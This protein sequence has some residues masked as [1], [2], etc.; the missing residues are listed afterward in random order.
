M[1]QI[2]KAKPNDFEE[3]F[4]LLKQ[5]FLK[6]KISKKKT[7]EIFLNELK[8]K[9]SMELVL[10]DKKKTIGYGAIKFRNDIQT[11]GKIGYLSELII[12]ESRRGKGLGTKLLKEIM[13]EAKKM[14]CKEIHFP[15]TFKRKKAHEFYN[16]LGFNKTA[17]FFW[18]KL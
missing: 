15:S 9:N 7:K 5:L 14:K 12:D 13:K 10:K 11:Q 16:T 18:K 3:I 8:T 2:S 1:H 6:N 4:D 17:Y